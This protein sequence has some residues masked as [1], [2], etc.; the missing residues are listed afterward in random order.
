GYVLQT[1]RVVLE[2][3]SKEL[4]QKEELLK[5]YLGEIKREKA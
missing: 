2:G 1:G 4:L 5:S 3:T